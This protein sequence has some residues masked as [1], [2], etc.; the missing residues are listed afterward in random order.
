M[1]A[2]ERLLARR[3]PLPVARLLDRALSQGGLS[4]S[5]A[6][7]TE[8][9]LQRSPGAVSTIAAC[10]D[11]LRRLRNGDVATYVVNRNIQFTNV[12]VKKCGFCAFSRVAVDDEGYF[13]PLQEVGGSARTHPLCKPLSQSIAVNCAPVR[14]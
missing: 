5:P 11:E 7:A 14:A 3:C 2:V 12:C 13:M 10:A 9:L 8:L 4:L 1:A 6:D